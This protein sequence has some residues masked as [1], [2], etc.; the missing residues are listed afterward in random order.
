MRVTLRGRRIYRRVLE[1]V[2]HRPPRVGAHGVPES[3]KPTP[4]LEPATPYYSDVSA[5]HDPAAFGL[6][7]RT[8]ETA[9]SNPFEDSVWNVALKPEAVARLGA[10]ALAVLA[11]A[12]P[13]ERSD[14]SSLGRLTLAGRFF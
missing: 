10:A 4:G 8:E 3:R 12:R 5:A 7:C 6:S 9:P 11:C 2:V 1:D 14:V 13:D